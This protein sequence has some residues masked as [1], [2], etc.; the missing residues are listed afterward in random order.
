[1]RIIYSSKN[2]LNQ[3]G[4]RWEPSLIVQALI[5]NA[6]VKLNVCCCFYNPNQI[7]LK[8][9]ICQISIVCG[10]YGIIKKH[11]CQMAM[12]NLMTKIF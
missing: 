7:N 6:I 8:C 5:H 3:G 2:K 11:S 9:R 4:N 12:V 10:I 1:M